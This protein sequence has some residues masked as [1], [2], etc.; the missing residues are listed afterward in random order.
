MKRGGHEI[1]K[2]D[3]VHSQLSPWPQ[4]WTL[5]LPLWGQVRENFGDEMNYS[6]IPL[7]Y[8]FFLVKMNFYISPGRHTVLGLVI[9]N[10]GVYSPQTSKVAVL[11]LFFKLSYWITMGRTT[12]TW[13]IF[14]FTDS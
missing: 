13:L 10:L 8:A 3:D 14:G 12:T 4:S 6:L 2:W 9:S 1:S 5:L 7:R 11:F